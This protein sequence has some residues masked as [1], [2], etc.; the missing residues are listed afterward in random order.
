VQTWAAVFDWDGVIVDSSRQHEEAW[1]RLAAEEHRPLPP[2]FFQRS[3]GMKNDK[4]LTELLGWTEDTDELRCLSLRK[5]SFFRESVRQQGVRLVPGAIAWLDSLHAAG[6]PCAVAS[7]TP[8]E[9]IDCALSA[10]PSANR[11]G[12]VVTAEDVTHGKPH[13]EVFL[14]AA[15]R[16]GVPPTVCVV[17]EDAQVGIAAARAAGMQ[18]VA[19]A[20]THPADSPALAGADRIV[21]GFTELRLRDFESWRSAGA[22]GG[23]V[24]DGF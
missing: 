21:A 7:S 22:R 23:R 8:R 9:N 5:E 10:L 24:G 13:P 19:V 14:T 15:A 4:V 6:I 18:V 12:A 3:F 17:F 16:L 1:H 20:T 11:F 2:G